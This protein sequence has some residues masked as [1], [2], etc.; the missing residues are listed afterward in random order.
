MQVAHRTQTPPGSP[1]ARAVRWPHRRNGRAAGP[2]VRDRAAGGP[3]SAIAPPRAAPRAVAGPEV[4]ASAGAPTARSAREPSEGFTLFI[5]AM[6]TAVAVR[7]VVRQA[8]QSPR[9]IRARSALMGDRTDAVSALFLARAGLHRLGSWAM[10]AS[11]RD[12]GA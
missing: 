5:G 1:S 10:G 2:A 8:R 6:L 4:T 7:E 3:V 12:A 11:S 9:M